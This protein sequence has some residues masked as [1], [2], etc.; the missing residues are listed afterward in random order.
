MWAGLAEAAL[1]HCYCWCSSGLLDFHHERQ[2][3]S[4]G[5]YGLGAERAVVL[6]DGGEDLPHVRQS[7]LVVGT[8]QLLRDAEPDIAERSF[9]APSAGREGVLD[10]GIQQSGMFRRRW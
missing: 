8:Q 5:Q 4:E 10:A 3:A 1:C 2:I 6:V 7:T 9:Q